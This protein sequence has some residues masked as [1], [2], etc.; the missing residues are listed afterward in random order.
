[1]K[2]LIAGATLLLTIVNAHGATQPSDTSAVG[3]FFK[4]LFSAPQEAQEPHAVVDRLYPN[5][6]EEKRRVAVLVAER[7]KAVLGKEWQ[8][9]A[10]I[11]AFKE[12]RFNCKATGPVAKGSRAMGVMQVMPGTA[13]GMGFNPRHLHDCRYGIDAGIEHM[14]RCADAGATTQKQMIRCHQTGWAQKRTRPR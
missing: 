13:R 4:R 12:S 8:E 10:V 11:I 2:S 14:R 9:T 6:S 1:M 3:S 5:Q 7:A